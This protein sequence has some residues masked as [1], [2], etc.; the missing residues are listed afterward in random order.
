[1]LYVSTKGVS[2]CLTFVNV[3]FGGV[4]DSAGIIKLQWFDTFSRCKSRWGGYHVSCGSTL[5][6]SGR[7]RSVLTYIML[8]DTLSVNKNQWGDRIQNFTFWVDTMLAAVAH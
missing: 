7:Q 6:L 4:L 1:M 5:K 8:R 3:R 2:V